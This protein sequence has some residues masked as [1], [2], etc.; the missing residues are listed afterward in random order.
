VGR[1]YE[2]TA[3]RGRPAFAQFSDTLQQ[4]YPAWFDSPA[5]QSPRWY[6]DN[7]AFQ[8]VD[9]C[10][11]ELTRRE[12]T[13][14]T[15]NDAVEVT[16][17]RLVDYLDAE[18]SR[19]ACARRVSHLMTDN[20]QE[21]TIA[22]VTILA[23]QQ[24]QETLQIE[25]LIPTARSAFNGERSFSFAPPEATLVS[26]A[27][28]PDPFTLPPEAAGRIDRLLF[29]LHLLYGQ[30][31]RTFTRSPAR[32]RPPAGTRHALTSFRT[33]N[34]VQPCALPSFPNRRW[35]P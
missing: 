5:G 21:L 31:L 34:F 8:F 2:G 27:T 1:D 24:F 16:L 9:A 18:D 25:E 26:Y 17:L 14:D 22:G 30:R 11:A 32:P 13:G 6:P 20:R 28:G 10:I 35:T 15:P 7:L 33:M 19:L 29:T 23:Y 4:L 12:E 3:L